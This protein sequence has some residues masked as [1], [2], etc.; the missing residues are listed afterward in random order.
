MWDLTDLYPSADAWTSEHDRV[1]AVTDTLD[2]YKG[3]LGKSAKDMLT[4]LDAISAVQRA[5]A[6]LSAYAG[7]KADE[8]VRIAANQERQQLAASLQPSLA[9]RRPGSRRK[10]SPSAPTRF[11]TSR[12]SNP[13]LRIA[14]TSSR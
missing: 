7:L 2:K 4:A 8:D 14:S 1:K 5:D 6:R 11:M 9:K 13:N 10:F 12:S 3:T